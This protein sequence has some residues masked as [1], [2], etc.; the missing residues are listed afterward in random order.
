MSCI[1]CFFNVLLSFG[2]A[3]STQDCAYSERIVR[4][5]SGPRHQIP[6]PNSTDCS[7]ATLLLAAAVVLAFVA[8]AAVVPVVI[9]ELFFALAGQVAVA[10]RALQ[11]LAAVPVFLALVVNRVAGHLVSALPRIAVETLAAVVV[12][13]AVVTLLHTWL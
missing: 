6:I 3:L 12:L 4:G 2:P 1:P 13:I 8:I 10:V 9:A 5:S 7:T 11:T